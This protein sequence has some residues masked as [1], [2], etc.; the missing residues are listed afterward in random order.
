MARMKGSGLHLPIRQNRDQLT[1]CVHA[2]Y[3]NLWFWD[4]KSSNIIIEGLEQGNWELS[5][6]I[7]LIFQTKVG[8]GP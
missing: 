1:K 7:K 4:L 6:K 2:A 8:G 3:S 5:P